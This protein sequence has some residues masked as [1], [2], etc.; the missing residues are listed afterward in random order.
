MTIRCE[1]K[2]SSLMGDS[3]DDHKKAKNILQGASV[4][5]LMAYFLKKVVTS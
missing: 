3:S 5:A 1:E 4:S 2:L